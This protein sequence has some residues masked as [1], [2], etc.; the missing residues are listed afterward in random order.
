MALA[1]WILD[2]FQPGRPGWHRFLCLTVDVLE[3]LSRIR[4]M[5]EPNNSALFQLKSVSYRYENAAPALENIDLTVHPGEKLVL[6]GANGCGK[7]TLL[8]L[9]DGLY[10]PTAG[11]ISYQNALLTEEAFQN[12]NFNAAFRAQVGLVFQDSDVQ[13]FLPTVLDE[14]AFAPLQMEISRQEVQERVEMALRELHIEALRDRAPHQLSSGEKKKVALASL[15]TLEPEV[16]LFD[17][18]SAG[19]DPRT[20]NWLAW[21]INE[22]GKAGK[23]IILATHDLEITSTVADRICLWNETHTLVYD[24]LPQNLLA[25]RE[26]LRAANLI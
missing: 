3:D 14:L 10:F 16:W 21:F 5:V 4:L 24:G 17:E 7:S 25:N 9:L 15:L 18:P 8:K 2:V 23:T 1:G 13:L 11:S 26:L 20:V 12:E 6:L 22:Q 19:L